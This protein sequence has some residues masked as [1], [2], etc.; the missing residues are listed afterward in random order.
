M[1]MELSAIPATR[2]P[3]IC[4][5][6]H[7]ISDRSKY[8]AIMDNLLLYSSKHSYLIYLIDLLKALLYNCFEN[9]TSEM[10]TLWN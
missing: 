4:A 8:S 2:Q 6:L 9:I 5:N 7:S 1:S 3:Y 10:S